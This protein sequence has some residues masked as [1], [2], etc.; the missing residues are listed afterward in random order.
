MRANLGAQLNLKTLSKE[1]GY[2][3]SHFLQMFRAATGQTPHRY[4]CLE[5]AQ[6]LMA[7]R[8]IPLIDVAAICGSSSPANFATAF[9]SRYGSTPSLYRRNLR[10][11]A[12]DDE[13]NAG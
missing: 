13:A 12:E 2:S 8:S 5:K 6:T 11:P 7:N 1:S 3:R 4:M 9:R 10:L